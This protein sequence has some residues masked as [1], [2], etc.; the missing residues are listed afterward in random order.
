MIQ[1][2]GLDFIDGQNARHAQ[3]KERDF[4]VL[5]VRFGECGYGLLGCYAS[6]SGEGDVGPFVEFLG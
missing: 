2:E 5:D 1:I 4:F 6:V 3:V